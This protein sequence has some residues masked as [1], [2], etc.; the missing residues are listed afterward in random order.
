MINIM[1]LMDH[2]LQQAYLMMCVVRHYLGLSTNPMSIG[3]ITMGSYVTYIGQKLDLQ[4]N[5]DDMCKIPHV[6]GDKALCALHLSRSPDDYLSTGRDTTK[7]LPICRS[8]S[9]FFG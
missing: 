6:M 9:P 8:G 2:E 3:M 4:F 5:G 1:L 7:S